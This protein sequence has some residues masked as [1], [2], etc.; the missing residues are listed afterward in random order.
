MILLRQII[1]HVWNG[2][3]QI[4]ADVIDNQFYE[5]DCYIRGTNLVAKYNYCN[6]TKSEYTYYTQNAHG[7]VVNL[8]DETGKVTKTYTYDAFGVEK[9][10]DENDTNAFRYCGEYYDAETGTIYLRARHYDPSSGRFTQRD[11]YA[12]RNE[13][14]LSLNKYTYCQNNPVIFV[15][16]SG[17]Y[18]VVIYGTYPNEKNET[19]DNEEQADIIRKG[20]EKA[21]GEC[22]VYDVGSAE[23]FVD[24]W[25]SLDDSKGIDEIQFIGHGSAR[26]YTPD[27]GIG[28]IYFGDDSRLYS[29]PYDI[30]N[31]ASSEYSKSR[32]LLG[33]KD[34]TINDVMQKN[35]NSIYF[36][37][38]NTSNLDFKTNISE[39]FAQKNVGTEVTGWD[40][41]VYFK[42]T[43]WKIFTANW[44][45][46]MGKDDQPT[47]DFFKINSYREISENRNPS[48]IS[49]QACG[50]KKP[51]FNNFK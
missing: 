42:R 14:P 32:S 45:E 27:K 3:K 17:K 33:C 38:C 39:A 36:S 10:I 30:N 47:F 41:G 8:T 23:E 34:K 49:F 51:V 5:A 20:Y 9:N 1:N 11:S 24:V 43:W 37:A 22:Y 12:G 21:Y 15:D 18:G 46:P 31:I 25:T 28:Y 16:P 6:G 13:E 44:D 48:K 40:G 26:K 4:V 19:K 29:S 35:V 7:D 50:P 2:S